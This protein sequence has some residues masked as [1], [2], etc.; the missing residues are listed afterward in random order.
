MVEP[1][2]QTEFQ[3][4]KLQVVKKFETKNGGLV[5]V[6]LVKPSSILNEFY[7]VSFDDGYSEVA[8]GLGHFITTAIKNAEQAWDLSADEDEDE[9]ENPFREV[10]RSLGDE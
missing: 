2:I 6:Y 1:Q 8:W 7:I 9:E 5:I 3:N 10:L 4:A